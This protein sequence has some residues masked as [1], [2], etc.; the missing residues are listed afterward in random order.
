[1]DKKDYLIAKELKEKLTSVV[2][3]RSLI[4]FGSRSKGTSDEYSDMDVSIVVA[5][6]DKETKGKIYD[7]VWEVGFNNFVVISP[8]I[9]TTDE[10]E[11]SPLRSAPIVKN[12]I[13]EGV[14]I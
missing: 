1:M 11:N 14:E 7:I 6:L 8:L 9:F 13:N 2:P 12:I 4:V 5:S 3:V 10:F